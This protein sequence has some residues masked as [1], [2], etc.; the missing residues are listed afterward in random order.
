MTLTTILLAAL[1]VIGAIWGAFAR[2]TLSGAA[3]ER[4]KQAADRIEAV[5]EANQIQNDVGAVPPAE[6]RKELGTWRP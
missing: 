5:E 1:A 2:G 6:A 4:A 3:K